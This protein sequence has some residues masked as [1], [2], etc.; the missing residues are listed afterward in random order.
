MHS[1]G[2]FGPR[3]CRALSD[4]RER[5]TP[6]KAN[7]VAG[8]FLRPVGGYLADQFNGIRVLSILLGAISVLMMGIS[9]L[10]PIGWATLL[11]FLAMACLGMGNGSVFQL[12]PLR[13]RKEI[14]VITGVVGAAGGLGGFFLPT[15]LGFF[16]DAAGSYGVGFMVF[17]C[18]SLGALIILKVVQR[19]WTFSRIAS[20][21]PAAEV[22]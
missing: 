21:P 5:S 22:A 10:P 9:F 6:W 1:L 12:V 8:S 18:A 15:I 17:A 4:P 20:S 3:D 7:P 2:T 13:F 14:G 19:G 11:I 16:K